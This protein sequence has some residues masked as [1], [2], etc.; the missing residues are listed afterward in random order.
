MSW[1]NDH[2]IPFLSLLALAIT[3]AKRLGANLW[4]A[5]GLDIAFWT[6]RRWV[7]TYSLLMPAEERKSRSAEIDDFLGRYI[8]KHEAHYK[9]AEIG[10]RL[11]LRLLWD[12]PGDLIDGICA[13]G[14]FLIRFGRANGIDLTDRPIVTGGTLLSLAALVLCTAAVLGP[15][16]PHF[17]FGIND[18]STKPAVAPSAS[19]HSVG[20][21]DDPPVLLSTDSADGQTVADV[22]PVSVTIPSGGATAVMS[23]ASVS[24]VAVGFGRVQQ[25]DSDRLSSAISLLRY[26]TGGVLV[27][28]V[29]LPV[30]SRFRKGGTYVEV[31]NGV[32]T[33]LTLANSNDVPAQVHFSFVDT[34][35]SNVI[36]TVTTIPPKSQITEFLD[37]APFYIPPKFRGTLTFDSDV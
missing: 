9:P 12:V 25:T 22:A 19:H 2:M 11:G 23:D 6:Y 28:E 3:I 34:S 31:G 24:S 13:G 18:Q 7:R 17:R 26:R 4:S 36:H 29:S 14:P 33:G 8:R 27:N 16:E 37:Q 21:T 20:S 1:L 35:R 5:F 32:N 15:E 10:V 30:S